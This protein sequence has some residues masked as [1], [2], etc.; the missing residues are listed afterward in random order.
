MKTIHSCTN[1]YTR[2]THNV[3]R[4]LH[5]IALHFIPGLPQEPGL[6]VPEV[7]DPLASLFGVLEDRSKGKVYGLAKQNGAYTKDEGHIDGS[8]I[9]TTN[10]DI[11]IWTGFAF[12]DSCRH[13]C[14]L[15][16]VIT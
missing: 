5:A 13:G 2:T 6:Q 1:T 9:T 8:F 10:S 4:R 12:E 14:F 3:L 11:T 15:Y 7:V 16:S